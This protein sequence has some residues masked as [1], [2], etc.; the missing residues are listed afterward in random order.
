[1]RDLYRD[2]RKNPHDIT[3][4]EWKVILDPAPA[5]HQGHPRVLPGSARAAERVPGF[6][7]RGRGV[8]RHHARPERQGGRASGRVGGL[9]PVGR[10]PRPRPR[11]VAPPGALSRGA[12]GTTGGA[13]GA[14][15]HGKHRKRWQERHAKR[16]APCQPGST[17]P[18]KG[19]TNR[20][21]CRR[22]FT[23]TS[24]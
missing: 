14:N 5:A 4:S 12:G 20:P 19:L 24:K 3:K 8:R 23:T 22:S 1:M 15:K 11:A 18:V 9:P 2:E 10:G 6:R 21:C 16:V 7:L 17:A 13:D